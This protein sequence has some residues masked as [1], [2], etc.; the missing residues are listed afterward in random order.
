MGATKALVYAGLTTI[1]VATVAGL[2]AP[3]FAW[4]DVANHLR[5][6]AFAI[7]GVLALLGYCFQIASRVT[8]ALFAVNAALF[9][10]PFTWSASTAHVQASIHPSARTLTLMSFNMAWT[11]RPVDDVARYI[12]SRAPDIVLLQEATSKHTA[13]LRLLLGDVYPHS[14]ACAHMQGCTQLVL[15]RIRWIEA[16]EVYRASGGPEMIWARFDDPRLGKFTVHSLHAAWPFTPNTQARHVD[17]LIARRRTTDGSQIYAGDFNLTPWSW[18]LQR[19]LHSSGMR[20][21]AM[22]LRSWPTDGQFH[23]P[24]P[25]FLIDHV[26]STPDIRTVAIETGP[27]LG[28][29]HLPIIAT[30]LLP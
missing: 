13:T 14:H 12:R 1:S 9:A 25:V 16:R 7:A 15:S 4:L 18:Q 6:F 23:L 10:L 24:G 5:P 11:D 30:L 3:A 19:L 27:S 8:A 28:S 29:D 17:R 22:L 21:H 26:V 2:I 20:R